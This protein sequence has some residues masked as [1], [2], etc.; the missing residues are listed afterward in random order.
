VHLGAELGRRG[1]GLVYGAGHSGLMG[2]LADAALAAGVEGVG[3]IPEAMLERE[4]AHRGL[5]RLHVVAGMH[6]RKALM[7]QLSDG[8]LALPGGIGTLEELTE[9]LTWAYLG[10]HHKPLAV[11]DVGGYFEPLLLMLDRMVDEGFLPRE[12]RALL[13][14]DTRLSPLLDRLLMRAAAT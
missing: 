5:H 2:T 6:E 8:F 4:W 9:V 3:V 11:L 14:R 7:A 1:V 10:F 13:D 12:A